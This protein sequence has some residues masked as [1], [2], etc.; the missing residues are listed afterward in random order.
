MGFRAQL[1]K[2]AIAHGV[3]TAAGLSRAVFALRGGL[4]AFEITR[5]L[6]YG[7]GPDQGLDVWRAKA[8]GTAL[9][10]LVLFLHGG[11]FQHLDRASH[12]GFAERF[13]QAGAVVFNA[14]YRLAPAHRY[15]AAAD[16]AERALRYALERAAAFGADPAQ[17]IVAG[18]SAGANL[19]LGLAI[20]HPE[21]VRA[22]AL[23]SGLLQVSDMPRLYRARS[24]S[25]FLQARVAS[26]G[27]DYPA[28][29]AGESAWNR[30]ALPD[31]RLDPLLHLEAQQT[32]PSDFPAAFISSGSADQVLE[33]SLR[34]RACLER[35]QVP[36]CVDVE[37]SG[38][39]GF[40]GLV[41]RASVRAV[42]ERCFAFMR[43][44]GLQ[45]S[46]ARS[47]GAAS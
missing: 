8:A 4:G 19:A 9:R 38:G 37:R 10:P 39:H 17:L 23:F 46:S 5:D 2:A 42:W 26:I 36:C 33:D 7:P 6:A 28:V 24:M 20:T 43:E 47:S 14:D 13:A 30:P 11:G 1:M 18:A 32:L 31:P 16:D 44:R 35:L 45:L 21:R 29:A 12:W 34:L 40:Q 15:P 22:A 25:R 27:C 3:S 41:S